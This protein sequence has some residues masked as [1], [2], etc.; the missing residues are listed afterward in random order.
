MRLRSEGVMDEGDERARVQRS[1]RGKLGGE[2]QGF[3]DREVIM[4]LIVVGW[5]RSRCCDE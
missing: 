3:I 1:T 4:P 2:V 5:T